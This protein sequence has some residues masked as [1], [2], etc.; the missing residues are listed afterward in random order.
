MKENNKKELENLREDLKDEGKKLEA[1]INL[2]NQIMEKRIH[3]P[4]SF[5]EFLYTIRKDPELVFRDIFQLVYDMT[6]YYIPEESSR[7]ET[8]EALSTSYDCSALFV[9]HC[10]DPYFVDR[11]FSNRFIKLIRSFKQSSQKGYIYLFEGPPGSGKSTFLN[12]FIQKFE[13]FTRKEEGAL[14]ETLWELD[15]EKL[16]G[17]KNVE[18][19][20]ENTFDETEMSDISK[21]L[22]Y[23]TLNQANTKKK[24]IEIYCPNHDHPILQIPKM[25]RKKFLQE[26][27]PDGK[28]KEKLFSRKEYEWV[29]KETSCSICTSLFSTLLDRLKDPMEVFKMIRARKMRFSRQFGEGLTV[30]NP[31]D[32]IRNK[33]INN[34]KI[35]GILNDL[36]ETH[37]INYVYSDLA[38]TNNGIYALMD[39]KEHN[40]ERLMKLHGII[41]DGVHK[42]N[43]LEERIKS[44]FIGLINPND[45]DVYENVPS[46]RDRIITVSIPYV[47]DYNTEVEIYRK[48]FGRHIDTY[49]L[50]GVLEN[51]AKIIL[52]SRLSLNSPT[53]RNWIRNPQQYRKYIDP[54]YLLL[55]MELYTG[56]LPKWLSEKDV[57]LFDKDKR[58]GILAE[59]E[60]EGFKGFSGRQS[61]NI[62]NRF[63][64]KYSRTKKMLTME[65]VRSFFYKDKS[66]ERYIP[67]EFVKSLED[68]YD[69]NVLQEV[70]ESIYSYNEKQIS[71]DIQNYLFAVNFEI[72]D[73]KRCL[74]TDDVID[75]NVEFF[76]VLERILLGSTVSSEDAKQFRLDTRKEYISKSLAQ[77]I[78]IQGKQITE[79]SLY[80]SLFNRYTRNLKENALAPYLG[81]ENFRR[82]ILDFHSP[83]FNAYDK[84]LKHDVN[85]MMT[86]MRNK[87]NYTREGARQICIYA[88]DNKLAEKYK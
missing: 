44:L 2:S 22:A 79:T 28:F 49:F 11:L 40:V 15:V 5:D 68:L 30:F 73:S 1:L 21:Q 66:L 36:F 35:Q 65:M 59:S 58:K 45:K 37:R 16:G 32:P 17:L 26:I 74:Y 61:L 48:K 57:R 81:N 83:N 69:Y 56:Q 34:L 72:G 3:T 84:R 24:F 63:F 62:F 12:N 64:A 46:F 39:I 42:V 19:T 55:K 13:E 78:N 85:L 50:P 41:S 51:F 52:S 76:I 60:E 43:S 38:K 67:K 87:F 80:K 23:L 9:E 70:K 7:V 4:I 75:I 33:P 47:L 86:N 29:H 88:L 8:R 27:I 31:G 71:R 25:Y 10:D 14:Y 54:N 20:L 18:N 82:A 6:Q 53:I 77:E